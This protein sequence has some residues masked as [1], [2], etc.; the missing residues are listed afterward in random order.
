MQFQLPSNLQTELIAYDPA[1]KRLARTE[2]AKTSKKPK[3]PIGLPPRLMPIEIIRDSLYNDAIEH[4]N[5]NPA[6]Q[7]FH[8]FRS[9]VGTIPNVEYVT[10]A[11][12]YHWEGLWVAAWMPPKGKES[13]YV[14]G[15]T[16]C[17]KDNATT[18]KM[19]PH[20]IRSSDQFVS[21]Q[22]G[23][24]HYKIN[25]QLVTKEMIKSGNDTNHW[26]MCSAYGDKGRHMGEA[27][28]HFQNTLTAS[29]PTWSDMGGI[30]ARL[31]EDNTLFQL[32]FGKISTSVEDPYFDKC[33]E[34]YNMQRDNWELTADTLFTFSEISRKYSSYQLYNSWDFIDKEKHI[35]NTPMFRKWIQSQYIEAIN[36]FNNPENRQRRKVV[37]PLKRIYHLATMI[38]QIDAVWPNTPLDY[39]QKHIDVLIGTNKFYSMGSDVCRTW[40]NTHMPVASFFQIIS[41]SYEEKLE[42]A[43]FKDK[44]KTKEIC[45]YWDNALDCYNFRCNELDDTFSMIDNVLSNDKTLEPPKRWRITEFHDHVQAES[46]KIK[47]PNHQLPQDLFPTPIKVTHQ[48]SNWSFFQPIDTHQLAQWGQAVRNCVGNASN[49]AE[50][51]R[52]KQHFIV[53][54]MLDGKPTFTIQLKVNHGVMSVEQIVGFANARLDEAGRATYTAVFAKALQAQEN[55]LKSETTPA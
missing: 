1:L 23:R 39:Y 31:K 44:N 22:V 30:F 20:H 12:I 6:A 19:L 48:E 11:V 17:Y 21:Q 35:L 43:I 15:Y 54:G 46:W 4:I 33:A 38:T 8:E 5:S 25:T 55:R 29:I 2:K 14:Y 42:E 27:V 49:Y 32:L 13:E 40:L 16:H 10:H 3:Y 24:S 47:N 53:L 26:F 52:K 41:K 50:G 45:Y 7:R 18:I 34:L 37:A 28:R 9:P 51:V 36:T